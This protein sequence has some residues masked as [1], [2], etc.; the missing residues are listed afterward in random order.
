MANAI[1]THHL[2][3]D[4]VICAW[5]HDGLIVDPG[6]ASTVPTLLAAL[7][8]LGVEPRAVLLT[9]IH[10]DHAGGTGTL[11]ESFP[12]LP[13]YVHETGAPH[14]VDPSRLLASAGRLYGE[15]MERLW[16]RIVPVPERNVTAL[17]GGERAEG[18]DVIATPGHAGHHVAYLDHE[19]GAAYVGDVA[20]VRIPPGGVTVMPTPPPEI[21]LE[22][23]SASLLRLRAAEPRILRLTHFGEWE[24]GEQLEAAE[25]ALGWARERSAAGEE[26]F[27][28]AL[29]ERISAQDGLAAE[30]MRQAMPPEQVWLGLER[31]W[32]KHRDS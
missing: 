16:G 6:P 26:A 14:L 1:D 19:Q 30:R 27:A 13:V 25:R 12:G 10:L 9:H 15:A 23:W 31:Y 5:E 8:E 2:G 22:A 28:A 29:A 21:D 24:A 4:R 7:R 32:R 20:R 3:N 18:L 17:A 11:L